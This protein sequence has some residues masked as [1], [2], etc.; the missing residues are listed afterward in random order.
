[1]T[2]LPYTIN[3]S[4]PRWIGSAPSLLRRVI[5]YTVA[6]SLP[7][8][9]AEKLAQQRI[10]IHHFASKAA[11]NQWFPWPGT[12]LWN[13]QPRVSL[14]PQTELRSF[15]R[16]CTS[17]LVYTEVPFQSSASDL[18]CHNII[19]PL[20]VMCVT[21]AYGSHPERPQALSGHCPRCSFVSPG[22][23]SCSP[24]P[25]SAPRLRSCSEGAASAGSSPAVPLYLGGQPKSS[26]PTAAAWQ[27]LTPWKQRR[28]IVSAH[29]VAETWCWQQAPHCRDWHFSTSLVTVST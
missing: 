15:P 29:L 2:N 25:F 17:Q 8:F 1:M 12:C 9:K 13:A 5:K 11:W 28:G 7:V 24:D 19:P 3:C 20:W 27:N 14:E 6:G 10:R 26:S 16:L 18:F 22:P 4:L 23:A 21:L